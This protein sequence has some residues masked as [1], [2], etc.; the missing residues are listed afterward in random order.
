MLIYRVIFERKSR[1]INICFFFNALGSGLLMPLALLYFAG[2][3]LS[4]KEILYL[5]TIKFWSFSLAYFFIIPLISRFDSK[6]TIIFS[7]S[8]KLVSLL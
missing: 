2:K 3:T 8:F 5:G 4:E 7:L 1:A 6:K